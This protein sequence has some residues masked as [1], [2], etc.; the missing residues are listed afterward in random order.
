VLLERGHAEFVVGQRG[1]EVAV[2]LHQHL[3][4]ALFALFARVCIGVRVRDRV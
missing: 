2:D 3:R 4:L 1:L